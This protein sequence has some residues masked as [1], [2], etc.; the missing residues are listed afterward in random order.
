MGEVEWVSWNWGNWLLGELSNGWYVICVSCIGRVVFRRVVAVWVEVLPQAGWQNIPNL[1][2]REVFTNEMG[3]PV[4]FP[5]CALM[6][7]FLP[8]RPSSTSGDRGRTPPPPPSDPGWAQR[9][10]SRPGTPG[11]TSRRR[12][13]VEGEEM[14]KY[15]LT[16]LVGEEV[17]FSVF[18]KFHTCNPVKDEKI[19]NRIWFPFLTLYR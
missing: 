18:W 13:A 17:L 8:P 14:Y 12:R 2:Q 16:H 10:W 3:H 15:K 19:Y 11:R 1:S 5:S 9:P 7:T 6:F 4:V